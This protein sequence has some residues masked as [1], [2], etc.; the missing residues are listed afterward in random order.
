MEA[1]P[2]VNLIRLFDFYLT[3]LFLI[4]FLR[5]WD[6]Y[7]NA[8]RL[9]I[10][11]RGRWPKLIQRLGEHKS[12]ILNRSFFRPALLA[13]VLT[14]AQLIA[15]RMIWP[16]AVLTGPELQQEWWWL[17]IVIA[18]LLPMLLVDGYFIFRAAAFDHDQT[19]K[20]FDLAEK[21]LGWKG[22]LVRLATL[23][24]VDPGKMVDQ[25]LKKSLTEYQSTLASSL[26][27]VNVQMGLRLLF[28]LTLWFVW[29]IR[30]I[31]CLEYTS[32]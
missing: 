21:W 7:L 8:V 22:P 12:M 1:R 18:T 25:E 10:A 26:W 23:G 11:V 5:R 30:S 17:P 31:A 20:Y 15:S 28:G 19:V 32:G 29:A 27:W 24:F 6:V 2:P 16:Q 13:L 14:I 3:L 9:L 4:S